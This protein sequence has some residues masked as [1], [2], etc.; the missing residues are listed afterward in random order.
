MWTTPKKI[1]DSKIFPIEQLHIHTYALLR[2]YIDWHEFRSETAVDSISNLLYYDVFSSFQWNPLS[3]FEFDFMTRRKRYKYIHT[4]LCLRTW[5]VYSNT[6]VVYS[7]EKRNGISF[8]DEKISLSIVLCATICI[9][10]AQ[11]F[12]LVY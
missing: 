6:F 10:L 4:C 3:E 11:L 9:K 2:Q 7:H 12:I 5:T 1:I 8:S